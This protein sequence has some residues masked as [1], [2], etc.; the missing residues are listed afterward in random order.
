MRNLFWGLILVSFGV[1]MLLDNLGVADFGDLMRQFWPV[2]LIFW[3]VAVLMRKKRQTY[4]YPTPGQPPYTTTAADG[5]VPPPPSPPPPSPDPMGVP[6]G[7]DVV[8]RS[9]VFG[10]LNAAISSQNFK[11]GSVSTI[12]GDTF[13]DLSKATI[14]EGNHVLNVHSIFGDSHIILPP[15]AAVSISASGFFGEMHV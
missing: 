12:F 15:N 2:L 5:S 9:E 14:G 13:L 7:M 1:L 11:G 6:Y 3:G 4:V 10:D 8:H